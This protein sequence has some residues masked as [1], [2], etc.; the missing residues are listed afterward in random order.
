MAGDLATLLK[1]RISLVWLLLIVLTLISWRVGTDGGVTA[2]LATVI[3][4]IVAFFKVRLVG[5]NF[6]ELR[7]APL[8]LRLILEGYCLVVCT[9]LIIMYLAGGGS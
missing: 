6:M 3:V 8:P 5:L 2:H 1:N 4:L 7:N 9:T